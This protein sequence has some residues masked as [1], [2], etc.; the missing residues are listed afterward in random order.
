MTIIGTGSRLVRTEIDGGRLA[1][2]PNGDTMTGS[3][4]KHP[5]TMVPASRRFS[6]TSTARCRIAPG[7]P[8]Q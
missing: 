5:E 1:G 2:V 6:L 8:C 4:A 7:A 3:D